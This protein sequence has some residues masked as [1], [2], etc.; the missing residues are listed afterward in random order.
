MKIY[1]DIRS[2]CHIPLVGSK[3]FVLVL[4][5]RIATLLEETQYLIRLVVLG[6][7]LKE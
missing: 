5:T 3:S 6:K 4:F 7:K 2:P 1:S